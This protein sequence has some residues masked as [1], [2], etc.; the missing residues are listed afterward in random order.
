MRLQ[1]GL[2]RP[3]EYVALGF[4]RTAVTG[5]DLAVSRQQILVEV[6]FRVLPYGI[7]EGSKQ[8]LGASFCN[9][10]FLEHREFDVV[11]QPTKFLYF[12][13]PSGFL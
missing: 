8:R 10:T 4:Y 9:A 13:L 1:Q 3:D 12:L 5:H 2:D 7:S 11:G 6:P